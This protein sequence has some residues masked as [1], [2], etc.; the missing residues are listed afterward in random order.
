MAFQ[1]ENSGVILS[2]DLFNFWYF[3][4]LQLQIKLINT[5]FYGLLNNS[6]SRSDYA[7]SQAIIIVEYWIG[8]VLEGS[9]RVAISANFP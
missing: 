9:W 8:T 6:V 5:H 4:K 7:S 2:V 3:H 1:K